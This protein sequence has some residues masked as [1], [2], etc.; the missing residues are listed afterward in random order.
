MNTETNG[1]RWTSIGL[2]GGGGTETPAI[3]PH[4]PNLILINC[5]MSGAYR[6][7]DGGDRWQ[8]L[9]WRQLTGCPFCA[10]VFHPTDP[11]VIFAAYAY[12]AKLRVSR[13]RGATWQPI[14]KGLPGDLRQLAIDP[15]EPL[16]MVAG[17]TGAVFYSRD[18]GESWKPAAGIS[19]QVRGFHFVRTSPRGK[20]VCITAT[21]RG[22][23]RSEDGG[24]AWN[25]AG[26]GL[27]DLPIVA[28]AGA[29][30]ARSGICRLYLWLDGPDVA[31]A[32]TSRGVV[33]RSGDQSLTWQSAA[34]MPVRA[35]DEPGYHFLLATDVAPDR[36][37]AV[38]P[39][40]SKDDTVLRSDDAGITWR[41]VAF[42]F[43]SDPRYNLQDNYINSLFQ[44]MQ[45]W[46]T[47]AAAI[48]PADPDHLLFNHY[49]SIFITTDGGRT[50]KTGEVQPAENNPR[51]ET[52]RE[53]QRWINNGLVNTTTWHHYID[54]FDRARRFIAYTDIGLARS[55]DSG[56]TWIWERLLGPNTY[57]IA[58]DPE[59]PGRAWAALALLHD[60]PNNNVVLTEQPLQ[61]RGC[62][63][64]TED[65]WVT[66]RGLNR[67][68]P[69]YSEDAK[70]D[71]DRMS[72]IGACV[73][74]I[75][76]DPRTPRDART[77][78][79]SIWEHG[80]FKSVDGGLNWAPTGAGVGVPGVNVRV[81][82]LRLHPDGTL[83]V[84]VTGKRRGK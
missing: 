54:P 30:N 45:G 37:Y 62:V 74:S 8:M 3:S 72:S 47:C 42:T 39:S 52:L 9:H 75:I 35:G 31:G 27:P 13:D 4:D 82:R 22:V 69:G 16:N 21:S 67:G 71:G 59:V 84:V 11:D 14:G 5:D 41:P 38:K 78:Y 70:Y 51:R 43:K 66:W 32:Q 49:C 12:A 23:F 58:F 46:S 10:P 81:C 6:T 17:T 48:D 68:L 7:T 20:R 28:F 18:G 34:R 61:S 36:L 63:G 53:R 40:F 2:S 50:W 25:A 24:V 79:A 64:Y 60:I 73:Q 19:A 80:V 33:F 57:E 44:T 29:S 15:D 76:L 77:L 55:T 65:A 56:A 26:S 83:F 1:A